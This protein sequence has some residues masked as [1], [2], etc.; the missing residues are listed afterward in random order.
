MVFLV[1]GEM[2][3]RS[4]PRISFFWLISLVIS[5]L[6]VSGYAIVVI[7][8]QYTLTITS[9]GG[10]SVTS[11]PEGDYVF[12]NDLSLA[13]VATPDEHHH[14]VNWTG[15][16]VEVG[17]V[18]DP[19]AVSTSLYID[20]DYTLQANFE[21]DP[22][23]LTVKAGEGGCVTVSSNMSTVVLGPG[24]TRRFIY[25]YGTQVILT[26]ESGSG[27]EFENWSGNVWSQDDSVT[28]TMDSNLNITANFESQVRHTLTV[29]STAGGRIVNPPQGSAEYIHGNDV[30][31]KVEPVDP[32]VF[33]FKG[34]KGLAV[35]AGDVDDPE[36]MSTSVTVNGNYTVV[37]CFLNVL[38]VI[39]VDDDAESDPGSYDLALSD[40]EENGTP[41]HPFDEIQE[42]I[43][44]A[45]EFA[46]I[47]VHEG[48]Y[49]ETI[50]FL[51]KCVNVMGIDPNVLE[52]QSFPVINASAMG[53]VVTFANQENANCRMSGFVLTGGYGQQAG[54]IVCQQA[55]PTLS[56]LVIAGNRCID[57]NEDLDY[58]DPNYGVIYCENSNSVFD[59][60]TLQGNYG[61]PDKVTFRLADCNIV[62]ENSILWDDSTTIDVL[63]GNDPNVMYSDLITPWPDLGNITA[64]PCFV[65]PGIWVDAT[66]M[67]LPI[68]PNDLN[69]LWI[70]GNYHLQSLY[71]HYDLTARGWIVDECTSPCID[72]GDP[73]VINMIEPLPN[74]LLI[75][76]GAYGN[77]IQ[78]SHSEE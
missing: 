70:M 67:T 68:E 21:I 13:I 53:P 9:S 24:E 63:S 2:I 34:W 73:S 47:R 39:H 35:D 64:D 50:D 56:H 11:P 6:G 44:V 20:D 43:E 52:P 12:N 61:G 22:H 32:N 60:C 54:A 19:A 18:T 17:K 10:G 66:D 16:A 71:G 65:E 40:P 5:A 48:T 30:V 76:Q 27:F 69:A 7:E 62:V 1:G 4:V 29:S 3:P 45:D 77:T 37:A 26:A 14:F 49:W 28:V 8:V 31:L 58:D 78:A 41:E 57:P 46:V 25:G 74:G 59:H 72:T 55:S 33:V 38:D 75:N 23:T 36:A 42:A 15:T 51:G